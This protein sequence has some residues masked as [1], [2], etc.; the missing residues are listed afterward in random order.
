MIF[1]LLAIVFGLIGAFVTS[2]A[3]YA[4]LFATPP[5]F[6]QEAAHTHF[7]IH[8][9]PNCGTRIKGEGCTPNA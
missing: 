2:R 3:L 6:K 4:F 7:R 8:T 9:C 5:Q 1:D